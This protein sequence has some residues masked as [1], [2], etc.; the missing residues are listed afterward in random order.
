MLPIYQEL[1]NK[2][3]LLSHKYYY[4]LEGKNSSQLE[5]LKAVVSIVQDHEVSPEDFQYIEEKMCVCLLEIF[6]TK[7]ILE[8]FMKTI[9]DFKNVSEQKKD[10]EKELVATTLNVIQDID[11]LNNLSRNIAT[12]AH[13][14][15]ADQ[16]VDEVVRVI[17]SKR[18]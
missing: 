9:P 11:K 15:S 1:L 6:D 5:Y 3:N 17:E 14:H 8:E 16:I 4:L 7:K 2:S 12:L 13:R 18:N 10:A